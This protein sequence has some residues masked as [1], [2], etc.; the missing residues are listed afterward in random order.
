[1]DP[2]DVS[3]DFYIVETRYDD[4][5]MLYGFFSS[6][7]LSSSPSSCRMIERANFVSWW[8]NHTSY[9]T[10]QYRV[11]FS[12]CLLFNQPDYMLISI[13]FPQILTVYLYCYAPKSFQSIFADAPFKNWSILHSMLQVYFSSS[14]CR[15]DGDTPRS[16]TEIEWAWLCMRNLQDIHPGIFGRNWRQR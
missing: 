15:E 16:I 3:G 4:Q 2:D 13:T 10:E 6:L 11:H 9:Y 5:F 14:I 12:A 7:S 8:D 1:M